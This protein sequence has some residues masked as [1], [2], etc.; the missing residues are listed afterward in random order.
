[1]AAA[2]A[3][4]FILADATSIWGG[5]VLA[6][7]AGEFAY[8]W[9]MLLAVIFWGALAIALR[10]GGRWWLLAGALEALVALSHGYA[11]LVAGFGAFAY[12]L[13]S[14]DFLQ[15]LRV[16]LQVHLLAFLLIG[17]WLIPLI[18]NLRWTIPNDS[19]TAIDSWQTLWPSSLWPLAAGWLPLGLM[20]ARPSTRW[21]YGVAFLIG[22]CLLG[23]LGF[24]AGGRVGL[25]D[26]RFFPYAQWALAVASGAAIAWTLQ[27]RLPSAALPLVI[28]CL[29]GLGAWWEP[30]L[31][32]IEGWSRWNLTGYEAKATWPHYL[33]T[34]QANAGPLHGPRLIF[35]HDPANNDLGSTRTLE[36][37]PMFG[38]RPALE[39]LFME[40]AVTGPFIYQLQA[41]IS[42][43]PSAPLSR[44]PPSK[45]SIDAAVQHLNE[46][47]V[48]RVILRSG[49]KQALLA[50]DPRFELVA[51]H[52]PLQTY[53]LKDLQTQL[54]EAVQTPLV[55]AGRDGWLQQ[56]F[57]RFILEHPYEQRTVFLGNDQ[58]L[59]NTIAPSKAAQVR[60][61]SLSRERLTFETDAVGQPHLVR[62][63]YHPRWASAN[64]EPI[65]LVEPSFMLLY[66][67]AS[68]VTLEYRGSWGNWVGAGA[69]L[70]GLVLF[71]M[72]LRGSRVLTP[73]KSRGGLSVRDKRLAGFLIVCSLLVLAAWWNDPE[74][75]YQ[76]G[77]LR[78][79]Q[80]N[81]IAAAELFDAAY[82]GRHGPAQKSE[83]LFWAARSLHL[84][85]RLDDARTRYV[86]LRSDYG[87]S[88][89]YPESGYRL[90][91]IHDAKGDVETVRLLY[92][93]LVSAI[94]NSKW[95]SKAKALLTAPSA[96]DGQ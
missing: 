62:I 9:G 45:R 61:Q 41:E 31:D 82:R 13:V 17:F 63:S 84:A 53:A 16:I 74:R 75:V 69:S 40:S 3:T 47:Y 68:T 77:H 23:L 83:A 6:Q 58:E 56:A 39:G 48:D 88:Y 79:N 90:I 35:E 52:G 7:L 8:S 4:G 43:R 11:L 34:A 54:I 71:V 24:V 12:L 5:N 46:L 32:R 72:G 55:A 89:W 50:G 22:I 20:L 30:R 95:T 78:F 64:G 29:I 87:E 19:A 18:E 38:S 51:E 49:Q 92:E 26:L 70:L 28:A 27:Q 65:Y 73:S 37:L 91:E 80:G 59:P 21:P 25:A 67:D 85:G 44:Y 57:R 96:L 93:Q 42:E 60:I 81:R 2:G 1:M 15:H 94:P 14:R 33:A 10:N 86:T 66:P 76:R 36:A